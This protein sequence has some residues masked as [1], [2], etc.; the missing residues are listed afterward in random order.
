MLALLACSHPGPTVVV[1]TLA[2][3]LAVGAG[4]GVGRIVLTVAATV[5]WLLFSACVM[6]PAYEVSARRHDED[7]G[8]CITRCK[9]IIEKQVSPNVIV[10]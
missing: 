2:G 9:Q 1:T 7:L 3:L 4:I 6:I 8:A 5:G 10:S